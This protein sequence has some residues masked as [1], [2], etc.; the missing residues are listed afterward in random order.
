MHHP[1]NNMQNLHYSKDMRRL[2]FK[3]INMS[4]KQT[5]LVTGGMNFFPKTYK[6]INSTPTER[7][8]KIR[9]DITCKKNDQKGRAMYVLVHSILFFVLSLVQHETHVAIYKDKREEALPT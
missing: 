2:S 4:C 6:G 3:E 5:L 8:I 7:H 9:C 1:E